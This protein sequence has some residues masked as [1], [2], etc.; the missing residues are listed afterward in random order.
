MFWLPSISLEPSVQK[1]LKIMDHCLPS[2]AVILIGTDPC[3]KTLR[4][5]VKE[6]TY[7]VITESTLKIINFLVERIGMYE[8]LFAACP[9]IKF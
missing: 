7:D 9:Y 1:P 5:R 6:Y 2:N 3:G 4:G 8:K